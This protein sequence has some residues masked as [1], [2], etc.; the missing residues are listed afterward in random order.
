MNA[1]THFRVALRRALGKPKLAQTVSSSNEPKRRPPYERASALY[2]MVE[3]D[4]DRAIVRLV[5]EYRILSQ[6][7]IERLLN[8]SK[9]TV[10]RLLRRLYDHRYLERVFL[11][12]TR[13][14]SSPALYILDRTGIELL[15][16]HGIEDFAW[17]PDKT[18]SS[19]YIEHTLAINEV[20][21]A[22]NLGCQARGWTT[23][24]WLSEA[25]LKS[26]ENYDLVTIPSYRQKVSLIPDS[27]FSVVVP[28]KGTTHF[29][30]ELD[31]GKMVLKRFREKIE[32]YVSYYKSGAYARRYNAQGFRVLTV[33][34]GVGEGRLRNL[35]K[36][37]T[38]VAGIGRRFWFAHLEDVTEQTVLTEPIW[39]VAGSDQKEALIALEQK[40]GV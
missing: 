28:D 20:R 8:R 4:N 7:Q 12:L 33:I 21:I 34:D 18:I 25:E 26:R 30:L 40:N 35:A 1:T 31:R 36:D 13:F 10:Q 16:R 14:G 3:R 23:G 37:A 24:R 29:F 5:Y 19:M 2:R 6:R 38:Q 22:V 17:Q 32:A 27:Y 9:P 11:P 39:W 15:R